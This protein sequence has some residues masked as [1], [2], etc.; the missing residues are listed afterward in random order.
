MELESR[1]ARLAGARTG[2]LRALPASRVWELLQEAYPQAQTIEPLSGT[3]VACRDLRAWCA[4]VR[5]AGGLA[6]VDDTEPGPWGCAAVRLGGHL[7]V[8]GL[9]EGA[10]FVAVARDAAEALPGLSSVVDHMPVLEAER[11]AALE[12]RCAHEGARWHAESD[13]AQVIASYLRCHPRVVEVRYPG[14]KDDPSFGV[15]ARTLQGG[16][17]TRVDYRCAEGGWEHV[18]ARADDP[19]TQVLELEAQ[20]AR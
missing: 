10:S 9:D 14:L 8:A 17:G 11:I 13:A 18:R 3:P 20:L 12:L 6:F 1:L 5:D 4:S 7:C 16:F 15:A 2:W 19:R